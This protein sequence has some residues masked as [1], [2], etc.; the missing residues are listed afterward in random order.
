MAGLDRVQRELERLRSNPREMAV[1]ELS[2]RSIVVR[3]MGFGSCQT[4]GARPESRRWT[5]TKGARSRLLSCSRGPGKGGATRATRTRRGINH[6][7]SHGDS[8]G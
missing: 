7:R 2:S 6:E 5:L 4:H 3:M 8:A 1:S